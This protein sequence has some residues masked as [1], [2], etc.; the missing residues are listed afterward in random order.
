MS[1]IKCASQLVHG[2]RG[3]LK[4]SHNQEECLNEHKKCELAPKGLNKRAHREC[5]LDVMSIKRQK[6]VHEIY[7]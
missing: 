2:R 6:R 4:H 5:D 7:F 1:S 3:G